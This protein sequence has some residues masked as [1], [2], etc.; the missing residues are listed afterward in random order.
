MMDQNQE[1][2]LCVY[3]DGFPGLE[4]ESLRTPV[5]PGF[6]QPPLSGDESVVEP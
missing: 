3:A 6:P 2:F 5:V 4:V 1:T